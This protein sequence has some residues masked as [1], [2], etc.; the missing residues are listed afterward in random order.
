MKITVLTAG[1]R[2][3]TQPYISLGIA[4]QKDG[5]SVRIAT[6]GNFK[7]LVE[8]SGLEFYLVRG[9]VMQVTRS[10][11]G[12]EEKSPDNPLKVMLSFNQLKKLVGDL[13]Q[14]FYNACSGAEAVVYHPGAAIGYFIAQEQKIPAI[15]ATPYAFT[16]TS[17]YPSLLFYHLPRLGKV[18][19]SL[20]HRVQGQIFWSA[21]SQ[22]IRDYWKRQFGHAPAD[23]GSPFSR[24][25]TQRDPTIISYSQ[26]V[27]PR[28]ARWPEHVH[29]TGYWFL[30]EEA[31]WQPPKNL[32]DFLQAGK[33]PVYVGFGS[34]G[35]AT[36]AEQKTRL[37][38]EALK[39]SGQRG[40][41]ATGW[42]AMTEISNLPETILMI[43]SAPHSWLFPQMAAVVHHGGAGTTAAGFRA[44]IPSII[45]PYGNDQFAWGLRAQELG[46]GPR[47]VPQKRLTA[48]AFSNAI[49][50]ALQ[51]KVI[52]AA[53]ALGEKISSE[54]GA[55]NA[56]EIIN[57]CW[58]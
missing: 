48:N 33:P 55:E 25:I 37:V 44:G 29:I 32:L 31:G 19:N 5:H 42:N 35:D 54:R 46:V 27:F 56:V 22:A 30:D 11:L 57:R 21:A 17:D 1:S 4:L 14:D 58:E 51:P 15:L 6:F 8:G 28:P 24:Q 52:D 43:E 36:L 38:I 13:Q 50:S 3:D 49:L 45:L 7:N 34:V 10:E 2:G 40:V 18:Y 53:R 41:L 39:Q 47:P 12:R 26:Y 20:T 23:F 9:D 16:P